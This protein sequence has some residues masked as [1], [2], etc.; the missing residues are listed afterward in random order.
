MGKP[1]KPLTAYLMFVI[2]QLKN[3]G[4]ISVISYMKIIGKKW[5]ELD[6]NTKTIYI[7]ASLK[8]NKKYYNDLIKWENDMAKAGRLDLIR[9]CA[10][11]ITDNN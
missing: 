11:S 3:R 1:S 2:E 9:P 7:E 6:I 4:D 8:E 5:K 10:V